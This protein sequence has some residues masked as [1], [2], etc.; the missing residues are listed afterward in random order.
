[1]PRFQ[2]E[3]PDE[4]PPEE[5]PEEELPLFQEGLASR[6]QLGLIELPDDELPEEEPPPL[7]EES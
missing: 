3:L 5:C 2:K 1:M 6:L 7:G 4:E